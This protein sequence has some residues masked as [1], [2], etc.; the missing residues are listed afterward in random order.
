LSNGNYVVSSPNWNDNRGAV[1]W[2]NGNPG[3]SG[4]VSDATSLVGSNPDDY[5]GSGGAPGSG[6]IALSNGNYVVDS[7]GWND[8]R[9]AVTWGNG[10]AGVIGPISETNSLV[11]SS[12]GDAVGDN[13]VSPLSN[14]SYVV[15][16]PEWN[17][18]RGAATWGNGDS[19]VSG[20]LS[21]ANSLIGNPGDHVGFRITTLTNGNYVAQS[22]LWNDYRGEAT[23][24]NGSTGTSGPVSAANSL[25]GSYPGDYVGISVI[26]LSNGNYA[27]EAPNWNNHRSAVTWGNGSTGT[28][29]I[30]SVANSLVGTDPGDAVGTQGLVPGG[31]YYISGVSPLSNGNYVVASSPWNGYRGAVT[32]GDGST[33][34][35]G[36]ISET[37]SLIGSNP[38][39]N[40]GQGGITPF[41]NG[42]YLALSSNWNDNRGA[43]TWG[44]GSTG[45]H[46]TVSAANSLVGSSPGDFVGAQYLGPRAY[47]SGI[48]LLGNDNYVVRSSLWNGNRGAVTWGNGGSGVSGTISDANSLIGSNSEDQLGQFDGFTIL[49]NSSYVVGST[50]A[51]TWVS[52]ATGQT[53]DGRGVV[54]QQNSLLGVG[55]LLGPSFVSEDV[56]HQS[57]LA[58]ASDRVTVGLTD[59]NQF[60]YARGQDQTVSLTPEFLT[61]TLD[62]GT[63]VV[64][65]A[66]NDITINSPITVNAGS[67]GGALTL[68]AGRS[69]VLNAS[70]TTDN[71]A[72]T[73]IANDQ[74]ANGVVDAQRDPGSAIISM[75][76]GTVLDTGSGTST[77]ELRDGAGLTNSDS[78][79]ITLQSVIAGSVAVVNEGPSS[80]S[81][82][83]LG[84]VVTSGVQSYADPHGITTVNSNL[85]AA[86]PITFYDSVVLNAGVCVDAGFGTVNFAGSGLQTLQSG[87]GVSLNNLLHNGTGTLQLCSGLTVLGRFTNQSGIFDA[88]NQPVTVASLTTVAGGT[89][90]AGVA[91]Q[92]LQ[93]GLVILAGTFTSSSGPMEA[94]GGVIL[95]GGDTSFG[96]L[97]GVGTVDTLTALGG[98]LMPGGPSPGILNITGAVALNQYTTV[99]MLLD[100]LAAGTGYAQLQVGGPISLGHSILGLTIGFVPPLGS[101]FEILTNTGSAP[102]SGTFAGLEEGAVFVQGGYQFQ[103]T[104]EGGTGGNSVVLMRVA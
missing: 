92:S 82:I 95:T 55:N 7:P 44:N 87:A 47:W 56:V 29:G 49:S 100:G 57:F 46:G 103:I 84:A 12:P 31:S 15:Q 72:L 94:S 30:V 51:A 37:N 26:P 19:G 80:G 22:Y 77:V 23:W 99:S 74:F 34:T 88:N 4:I 81:D 101:S 18:S 25:V 96:Q 11:G 27:I 70:I 65:Q 90:L 89:Y 6:V 14:G 83:D 35:S 8:T 36:T 45:I 28:S 48:T 42:N 32:W 10:S 40:V 62:T 50:G 97:S 85:T 78:G 39:D 53:L 73:L 20:I 16:S 63:A 68:Q 43:V 52:G 71:G 60:C 21:D 17:D 3:V 79:A 104:Y 2:G 9:G 76:A 93:G 75:A 33:G 5:V 58:A 98:L 38:Q 24:G 67:Q 91:P 1:T 54:T 69:I 66:S 64:L 13:G 41:N 59:P 86:N 61:A 102:I